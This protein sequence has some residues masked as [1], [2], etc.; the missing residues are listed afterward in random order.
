MVS[1]IVNLIS[2]WYFLMHKD[3]YNTR[4]LGSWWLSSDVIGEFA[5][6]IVGSQEPSGEWVNC[7]LYSFSTVGNYGRCNIEAM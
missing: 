4:F 7:L 2:L 1:S 5:A 6:L 3:L